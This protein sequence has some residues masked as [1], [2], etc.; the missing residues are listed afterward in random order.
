MN[1]LSRFIFVFTENRIKNFKQCEKEVANSLE[2]RFRDVDSLRTKLIDYFCEDSLGFSSIDEFFKIFV[3][4]C[5]NVS[6]ARDDNR[7]RALNEQR[8]RRQ[9]EELSL[10]ERRKQENAAQQQ[11]A[12]N[13]SS[14]L[15]S[16]LS[17]LK[18]GKVVRKSTR[19]KPSQIQTVAVEPSFTLSLKINED[20]ENNDNKSAASIQR[21]KAVLKRRFQ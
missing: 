21:S 20:F 7:L 19:I 16:L 13:N 5:V 11:M 8:A 9:R 2:R 15:D 18:H 4:L 17:E 14:C 10:R 3:E 12:R 1:F 6:K